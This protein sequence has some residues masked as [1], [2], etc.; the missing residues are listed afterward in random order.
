MTASFDITRHQF[1]SFDGH[2]ISYLLAGPSTGP[3]VLLVHGF[4][5]DATLNWVKGGTVAQLAEAGFRVTAPDLRGHGQSAKPHDDGAYPDDVLAQDQA[6]LLAHL[7]IQRVHLVGY[8]L[9]AITVARMVER[10][11]DAASMV[12]SGMGDGLTIAS[13][14][15]DKFVAALTGQMPI[16]DPFAATVLGFV[17]RMRGDK[18]A[19]AQVIRGRKSVSIDALARWTAPCLVLNGEHDQ[20][21]G[22]GAALAAMIPGARAQSIAGNHMDAILKP[23]FAQAITAF[24]KA[25]KPEVSTST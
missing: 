16:S 3:A 24:L 7:G 15:G 1:A 25:Q 11:A 9:G 23:G 19:L 6:A 20:D 4:V 14:R 10:G 21:N 18:T 13:G 2:S 8:S 22:D 12:L 17:K 5:S